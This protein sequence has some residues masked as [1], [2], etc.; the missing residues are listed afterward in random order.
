MKHFKKNAKLLHFCQ[1]G[2]A[3]IVILLMMIAALSSWLIYDQISDVIDEPDAQTTT[4]EETQPEV[5]E[6]VGWGCWCEDEW[7]SPMSQ[8]NDSGNVFVSPETCTLSS[9]TIKGGCCVHGNAV[10]HVVISTWDDVAEEPDTEVG[11]SYTFTAASMPDWCWSTSTPLPFF[12]VAFYTNEQDRVLLVEGETYVYQIKLYS[13]GGS[14]TYWASYQNDWPC[15]Y[16][17][18]IGAVKG[19]NYYDGYIYEYQLTGYTIQDP[20]VVTVGSEIRNDG[21]VWL[22]GWTDVIGEMTCGFYLSENQTQL[23]S[24]Q[25]VKFSCGDVDMADPKYYFSYRVVSIL[26][27]VTYYYRAY[28]ELDGVYWYGQTKSFQRLAGDILPELN[29]NVIRNTPDVVEFETSLYSIPDTTSWNVTIYYGYTISAC[30]SKNYTIAVQDNVTA[31]TT[32]YIEEPPTTFD[33]GGKYYYQAC[34]VEAEGSSVCSSLQTFTAY[35]PDQPAAV[36]WL[37][38]WLQIDFDVFWWALAIIV[39]IILWAIAAWRRQYWIGIV[40]T[41]VILLALIIY[42]AVNPWVVVLLAI[43]CGFII[44]RLVFR[45]SGGTH[46]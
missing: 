7:Y 22:S 18:T 41:F 17:T 40:G 2:G 27:G 44:F 13:G 42:G 32:W 9:I 8:H 37:T 39:G 45:K 23:E 21:S 29:C 34:A 28:A 20:T 30:Y 15:D 11:S 26:S 36:N 5:R 24:G 16:E 25:G 46:S 43:V 6:Y 35:D 14:Q 19:G 10:F 12:D 38:G 33:Y 4:S 31:D 3:G 1:A